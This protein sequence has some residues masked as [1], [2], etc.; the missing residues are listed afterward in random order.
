MKKHL[1]FNSIYVLIFLLVLFA[2]GNHWIYLTYI[3]QPCIT[4]A[5][6][7]NFCISTKLKGRFHRR[8][9]SGLVFALTGNTLFMIQAYNPSY[10]LYG[11]IAYAIFHI[12]YIRAFYLDFRSA[13]ELDKKGARVA[14]LS[15]ALIFPAFYFYLRPHLAIMKLPVLV[16]V[17]ISALLVMMAAFR[18]LRVN[19]ESFKLIL[20]G[21]I[22]LVASDAVLAYGRFV[23]PFDLSSLLVLILYGIA[24]YLIVIGGIERKLIRKFSD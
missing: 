17:M 12:C 16:Y 2:V 24:Q 9:F 14:I 10:V 20:A 15:A 21:V 11:M 7:V 6:L 4:I 18:N 3:L 19:T 22:C 8:L 1:I 5:L 13:Q 23:K